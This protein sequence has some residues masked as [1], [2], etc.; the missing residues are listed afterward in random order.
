MM[1]DAESLCWISAMDSG[2]CCEDYKDF[3]SRRA[4]EPQTVLA[5]PRRR[6]WLS[7]RVVLAPTTRYRKDVHRAS[8]P[9]Y[10]QRANIPRSLLISEATFIASLIP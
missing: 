8:L 7:H 6:H 3:L 9:H 5:D 4:V 10:G 1:V 2:Y